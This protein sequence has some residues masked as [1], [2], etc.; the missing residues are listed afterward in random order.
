VDFRPNRFAV[1]DDQVDRKLKL[2]ACFGS[3][4]QQRDY[5]EPD[6]VVATARYW[7][8]YGGGRFAEPLEVIRDDGSINQPTNSRR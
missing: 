8:R 2:L 3:Q 5:L 1:I 6:L 4:T 7:S